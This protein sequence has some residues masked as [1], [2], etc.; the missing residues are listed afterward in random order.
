VAA[1]TVSCDANSI[2][3]FDRITRDLL[4]QVEFQSRVALVLLERS[5]DEQRG[6]LLERLAEVRGRLV[7]LRT[8]LVGCSTPTLVTGEDEYVSRL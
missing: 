7:R 5:S 3:A 8:R 2:A 4:A 1:K 6:S